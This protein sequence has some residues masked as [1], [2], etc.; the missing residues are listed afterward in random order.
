MS[1]E[2]VYYRSIT[3]SPDGTKIMY[4]KQDW[5]PIRE[6]EKP[7]YSWDD[8]WEYRFTDVFPTLNK[9]GTHFAMTQKQLGNS[10]V[11]TYT[12]EGEDIQLVIDAAD[13]TDLSDL[14]SGTAGCFQPDW[15]P[16]G[17]WIVVGLGYFFQ[18]RAESSAKVVRIRANGTDYQALTDG[19]YNAAFPSYNHDGSKIVFRAWDY[20]TGWTLGLKV[21]D[22]NNNGTISNLTSEWDN[23]PHYNPDGSDR[24]LFTRR[25]SC[26]TELASNYD[27]AV[28]NGDGTNL[29]VV[30]TSL[31]NEAHAVWNYDG[32][33]ILYNSGEYG[34]REECALYDDTFQP[35]GQIMSM[36]PDGSDKTML[37]DTMW[38]DSMPMQI[39]SEYLS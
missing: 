33:K 9:A 37:I 13:Y 24:I 20:E 15:S 36:N 31:A 23:L 14:E 7:L 22:L 10:S 34:F 29:T 4:E 26:C 35:Y 25:T 5:T 6:E 21:I 2:D 19:T 30:T 1:S 32:S 38:E 17:E 39:P 18:S 16:D 8:E 3:W 11:V 28:M 12:T 27:I